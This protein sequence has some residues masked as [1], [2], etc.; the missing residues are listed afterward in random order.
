M[1]AR[2]TFY[3]KTDFAEVRRSSEMRTQAD[4]H[5][6]PGNDACLT[7]HFVTSVSQNTKTFDDYSLE[8]RGEARLSS[9]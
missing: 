5:F 3:L 2:L 7:R 1:H 9:R 4:E 6:P 8:G